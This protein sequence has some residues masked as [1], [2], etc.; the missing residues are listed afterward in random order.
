MT[1]A[2]RNQQLREFLSKQNS[3]YSS[4]KAN[5]GNSFSKKDDGEYDGHIEE[6]RFIQGRDAAEFKMGI[7]IKITGPGP[8]YIGGC[9]WKWYKLW[10][11]KHL[12]NLKGDMLHFG[13]KA[14]LSELEAIEPEIID[15]EF[16]FALSTI[17]FDDG[18]EI[19]LLYINEVYSDE[20]PK[21]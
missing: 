10:E 9:E 12:E 6:V 19:Q 21:F 20:V 16:A 8:K 13:V 2:N 4:V 7:K 18:N 5:M 15:R 17:K 1:N 11:D 14:S 3:A